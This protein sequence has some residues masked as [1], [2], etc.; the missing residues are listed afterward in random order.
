MVWVPFKAGLLEFSLNADGGSASAG[1]GALD[2][3]LLTFRSDERGKVEIV[4]R[5][6]KT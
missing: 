4:R 1:Q 2:M 5:S 6:D 3:I